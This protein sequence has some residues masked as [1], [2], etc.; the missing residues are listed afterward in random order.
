MVG[1]WGWRRGCPRRFPGTLSKKVY[2]ERYQRRVGRRH[3]IIAQL[4]RPYPFECLPFPGLRRTPEASALEQRHQEVELLVSVARE[5]E[6]RKACDL[7]LDRELFM[8]L[9]DQR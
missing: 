9:A 4:L 6:R 3:W 5:G 2:Q 1:R 8:Q 7:R